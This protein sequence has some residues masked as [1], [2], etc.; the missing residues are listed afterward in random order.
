MLWLFFSD[1]TQDSYKGNPEVKEKEMSFSSPHLGYCSP[2]NYNN[3]KEGWM[4]P[5]P[6][7]FN[8]S[9]M[10]WNIASTMFLNVSN[11]HDVTFTIWLYADYE[12][13]A[14][15]KL[16]EDILDKCNCVILTYDRQVVVFFPIIFEAF[17]T[18]NVWFS[19]PY[20]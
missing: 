20:N 15:R 7:D 14:F 13:S 3:I 8:I 16:H 11:R 12:S 10:A 9:N 6:F 17:I 18:D 1:Q 2:C 4:L 19:C 5:F